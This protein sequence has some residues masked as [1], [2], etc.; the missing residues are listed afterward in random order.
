[1]S[2]LR[3]VSRFARCAIC[4]MAFTAGDEWD[5][6]HTDEDGED[7]HAACCEAEG[8]CSLAR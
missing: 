5:D 8:P 3:E 1:M 6:R 4:E 2:R 7:I